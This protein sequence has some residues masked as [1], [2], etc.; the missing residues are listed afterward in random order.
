MLT[1]P[2]D[3]QR[4]GADVITSPEEGQHY[5]SID[6][7][8]TYINLFPTEAGGQG[9]EATAGTSPPGQRPLSPTP[10][11]GQGQPAQQSSA[12]GVGPVIGTG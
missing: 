9:G 5:V 7:K 1:V 12:S 10:S 11:S 2:V 6:G 3:Q 4:P 8:R